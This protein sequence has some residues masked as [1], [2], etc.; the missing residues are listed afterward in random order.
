MPPL[1]EEA[2]LE[3][4]KGAPLPGAMPAQPPLKLLSGSSEV[5]YLS[6]IWISELIFQGVRVHILDCA[7]RF[8]A[9][10]LAEEAFRRGESAEYV[11][12]R[13]TIQRA[14]TPYQILD[15]LHE[16][17]DSL[18]GNDHETKAIPF[19]LA[20][21][22]QFFDGDVAEDE[23]IFLLKKMTGIF[24]EFRRKELPLVIV[25][26]QNYSNPVFPR[27][28]NRMEET[29][30]AAWALETV[31]GES[32]KTPPQNLRNKTKNPV[33]Y[34][35]RNKKAATKNLIPAN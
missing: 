2:W 3:K 18:S 32:S 27:V 7:I 23:G 1:F 12:N 17:L 21:C 6:H 5:F 24:E 19:I 4:W 16:T 33:Q 34:R 13:A 8:N 9:F 14:F 26:K 30:G 31:P 29:A 25:E 15:A 20:P 28:L 35:L 22:K 10:L 11:L